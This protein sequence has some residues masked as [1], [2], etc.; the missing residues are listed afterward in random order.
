M[1]LSMMARSTSKAGVS[2]SAT[3]CP[4][5][6]QLEDIEALLPTR[7]SLCQKAERVSVTQLL[8]LAPWIPGTLM[9]VAKWVGPDLSRLQMLALG[10]ALVNVE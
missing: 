4:T 10:S 6:S 1:L 2:R 8:Q 5:A 3:D 9:F 7:R